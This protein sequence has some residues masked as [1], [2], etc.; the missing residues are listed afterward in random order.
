MRV[1]I[2]LTPFLERPDLEVIIIDSQQQEVASAAIISSI[3]PLMTFTM[4][5]RGENPQSPFTLS[6]H[7]H[8]PEIGEVHQEKVSFE[9]SQPQPPDSAEP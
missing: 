5:L 4:H 2:E 8:Y 9:T 3:D 6:A 7:L 1:S